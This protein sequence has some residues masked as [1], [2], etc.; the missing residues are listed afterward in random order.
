M[1][2][3]AVTGASPGPLTVRERHEAGRQ[4]RARVP[5]SSHAEWEP[6]ADRPDVVA[7]LHNADRDLQADLLPL[8]YERMAASPFAFMRGAAVL[9]AQD[10]SS[11]A[12]TGWQVQ[13]GGDT[14]LANFGAFATP[15]RQ[16][17]FDVN[18]FDETLRGPWEWDLKRLAS[19]AVLVG[20]ANGL[21]PAACTDT[22]IAIARSYRLAMSGYAEATNLEVFYTELDAQ[23]ILQAV[24]GTQRQRA[25]GEFQRAAQHDQ[26]GA[27]AKLTAVVNGRPCIVDHPPLVTHPQTDDPLSRARALRESYTGSIRPD[28]RDFLAR[29]TY[30]DAARKVV[31]V[32]S[33]GT[34]CFILLLTGRDTADPLVL[35]VKEARASVLEPY[36]DAAPFSNHGERVVDGQRRIQAASDVFLGWGELDGT[37]YYV[38]QLQDMKGSVDL[39]RLKAS[40]LATYAGL[41]GWA[42]ARAHARSGDPVCL[43]GYLGSGDAMDRALARFAA[44]YADQTERDHAAFRASLKSG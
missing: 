35:Q 9:M 4:M 3:T 15:E 32:G 41:C 22:V 21:P 33:V 8:R 1:K 43:A 17:V 16:L 30:V 27:L 11:T 31:G 12:T 19:S 28:V 42:L 2:H 5:R 6:P 40:Q 34:R 24:S 20:R 18:D 44:A 39:A 36:A 10:L 37:H 7:L 26:L 25:R 29:Y 23:R 38:R 14:H 13:A